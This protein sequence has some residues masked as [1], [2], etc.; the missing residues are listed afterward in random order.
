MPLVIDA[1]G[2][3]EETLPELVDAIPAGMRDSSMQFVA[4]AG[5]FVTYRIEGRLWRSKYAFPGGLQNHVSAGGMRRDG[6]RDPKVRLRV[7]DDEGIDAAVL[8][9]SVGLMFGL[10]EHPDIAAALCGAYNDWLAGYCATDPKRLIGVALLPQQDPHLA[11]AELE[12]A[13]VTHGFVGGVM[14][15]NRIG[16]R[17]V[18]HPDF[19]VLWDR[20][21]QIDVPVSFHEAYLSGIDTVGLDRMSSYAGCHIVSHVFRADERHGQ[22]HL[23]RDL[24]TLPRTTAGVPRSW[25]RVGANVGGSHRRALRVGRRRLPR[26]R[27]ERQRQHTLMAHFRDRGTRPRVDPRARMGR[28]RDVRVRLPASRRRL[29]RSGEERHRTWPRRDAGTKNTGRQRPSVL[30]RSAPTDPQQVRSTP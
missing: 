8:Y 11:A 4:E 5:G 20:A 27:P 23:G 3:V 12:R 25:L 30:R 9:P 2:H 26:G 21:Q 18:D 6:G 1:D 22:H 17:T 10:I 28:Q 15:P 16:G 14:R 13:V 7:L 29:S 24:P 19:D